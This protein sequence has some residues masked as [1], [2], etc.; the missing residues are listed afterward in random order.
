MKSVLPD[1]KRWAIDLI[2]QATPQD[3][4]RLLE[5]D[6]RTAP[7]FLLSFPETETPR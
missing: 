1:L 4:I 3:K 5:M 2:T 7:E 6:T